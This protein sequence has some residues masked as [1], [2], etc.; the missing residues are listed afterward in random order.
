LIYDLSMNPIFQ[1]IDIQKTIQQ[2]NLSYVD[3]LQNILY[4]NLFYNYTLN[5]REFQVVIFDI[6]S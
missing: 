1:N 4:Q 5:D 6:K 3:I 2:L